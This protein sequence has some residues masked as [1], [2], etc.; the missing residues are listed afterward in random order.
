[1][2]PFFVLALALASAACASTKTS[3]ALNDTRLAA[4]CS[5]QEEATNP[6]IQ[7]PEGEWL[8]GDPTVLKPDEAPDGKWHLFANSLLG[9]YHHVSPDGVTWERVEPILFQ[10]GYIRP[11]ILRDGGQYH[12]F[13]ERFLNAN[14]SQIERVSSV[15]LAAWSTPTTVIT[16][17]SPGRKR[18]WQRWAT[19]L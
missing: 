9:I 7:P 8:I 18:A 15:D 1:M 19:R 11:F 14:T 4:L 13:Y 6:L 10:L 2:R 12:L 17:I 16:P 3:D 5:W